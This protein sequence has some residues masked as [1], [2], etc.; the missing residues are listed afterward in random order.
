VS[1]DAELSADRLPSYLTRFV[2]GGQ[3]IAELEAILEQ[4]ACH[5]PWG[6]RAREGPAGYRGSETV[7]GAEK[8]RRDDVFW[9]PDRVPDRRNCRRR[10]GRELGC[11]GLSGAEPLRAW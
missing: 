8:A 6:G 7:V 4:R 10:S 11:T 9:V 3:E 1:V 5:D 2:G